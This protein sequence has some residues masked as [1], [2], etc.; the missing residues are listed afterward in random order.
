MNSSPDDWLNRFRA[1]LQYQINL[2]SGELLIPPFRARAEGSP[3]LEAI[4]EELGE[5]TRCPLHK[6]RL[7]IVFG[8]GNPHARLMFVGEGP[9][10]DEDR[11]GRPFVGRAGQLLT[12]MIKAMNLERSDIYI[13]NVV[14]CRPPGNRDPERTEIRTCLPFLEAQ[15][16]AV[17][18][19]IIVTLGRIAGGTLLATTTPVSELRGKF[20]DRKGIPVMP[21]YHP[22]YL[23]RMEPDRRPKAEAWAD[24]KQVMSQ[25]GR[26]RARTG[27]EP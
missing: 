1:Y 7:N 24:L 21:T 8:E 4:R 22:S 2:G 5:C 17:S 3:A 14:K 18:P 25:L 23:L 16:E 9:G 27:D 12:K 13:S 15:I 20:H 6:G 26:A 11:E 10:A 19:E